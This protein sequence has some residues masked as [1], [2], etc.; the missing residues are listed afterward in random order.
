MLLIEYPYFFGG[1]SAHKN[2][3]ANSA[4]GGG[5][6]VY[7]RHCAERSATKARHEINVIPFN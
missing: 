5:L 7:S 2:S 6:G 4:I 3:A 1:F